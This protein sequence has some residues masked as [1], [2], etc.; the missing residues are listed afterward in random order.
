MTQARN[1]ADV[2]FPH[3]YGPND[4]LGALN[5]IT[6]EKVRQAAS[7]VQLGRCYQLGRVLNDASPAQMWR[8]WK[9]SLLLDH[10]LPERFLG[11]NRQSYLEESVA[12]A[13]H[14]GT[15]LDSLGHAGIGPYTYNGYRYADI[16]TGQGLSLLGIDGVTPIFTRGVVLDL[17]ASSGVEMLDDEYTVTGDDLRRAA[18]LQRVDVGAGDVLLLH[19]GWGR[20]WG[21]DNERYGRSEPGIGLNAAAW[22]TERRV[23]V[24]GADNWAVE[25]VPG[26]D[27][28]LRFPVH[29]HCITLYGCYLLE[30]VATEVLVHDGISEFCCVIAP[31]RLEGASASIVSPVAI[32]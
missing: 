6:P 21:G 28:D 20:L 19:T 5:E 23:A 31:A 18:E 15:H 8:Y 1:P 26:E 4:T 29:Q 32:V 10:I 14:S 22:C 13:L 17:A 9:Q 24:I 27:P 11:A 30:N 2:E 16:V 25:V 12:G 7:L 3:R